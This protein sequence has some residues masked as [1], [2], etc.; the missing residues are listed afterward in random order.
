MLPEAHGLPAPLPEA[1]QKSSLVILEEDYIAFCMKAAREKPASVVMQDFFRVGYGPS[2]DLI[3]PF[4]IAP[5]HELSRAAPWFSEVAVARPPMGYSP[6]KTLRATARKVQNMPPLPVSPESDSDGDDDDG[7]GLGS[8]LRSSSGGSAEDVGFPLGMTAEPS[9]RRGRSRIG[10]RM[11][12]G[13]DAG[14]EASGPGGAG[15]ASSGTDDDQPTGLFGPGGERLAA[16]K[17]A[18]RASAAAAKSVAM[19][20]ATGG[21]GGGKPEKPSAPGPSG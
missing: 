7:L 20:S 21:M 8:R 5:F 19:S 12:R 10:R 4:S 6:Q 9:G 15:F 11:I 3:R 13:Y 2:L 18:A 16:A 1:C 14:L 17:S